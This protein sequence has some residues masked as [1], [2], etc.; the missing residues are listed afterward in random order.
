MRALITGASGFVGRHLVDLLRQET[1]WSLIGVRS[2]PGV[3]IPGAELV[4]CDLR[5]EEHVRRVVAHYRPDY[6]FHLAAQTYV[7]QAIAAPA[8][9]L[10]TNTVAQI[11]LLEAIRAAELNPVILVVAS[12]E[13]YGAAVPEEMPL[14][15][16]QPFRPANPYAVSK[17]VQDLLGLQYYLS[18]DM[19]IVRVR[20]FNHI[21]PGQSDRFVVS[22]LA[23]QVAQAEAGRAEPVILVGNL[24]AERDFLDARDVVRAYALVTRDEL[25]GEVFNVAS[26]VPRSISAVVDALRALARVP[27]TVRQD[28]ARLRPAD[29][30]VIYGDAAKLRLETGWEPRIPFEQ[31]IADTLDYWRQQMSSAS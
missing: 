4:V 22:S 19:R 6:V 26:G 30:P 24:D 8:Q 20:P 9:T 1:D 21:G 28:E 11:N 16:Q 12:S 5:D 27:I 2:R 13:I 25:A 7:P 10:V 17:A 29:V 14:D 23:R 18:Y 15:E 3:P 31:S